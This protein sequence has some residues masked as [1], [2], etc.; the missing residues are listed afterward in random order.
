MMAESKFCDS[1][2]LTET[3]MFNL[4]SNDVEQIS[5]VK[6]FVEALLD[7]HK[8]AVDILTNLSDTL[9]SKYVF[10]FL[11]RY[12]DLLFTEH[13][14]TLI[15]LKSR[16]PVKSSSLLLLILSG[17]NGKFVEKK[18]YFSLNIIFCISFSF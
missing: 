9:S 7:Y 11:F 1:K 2:E 8:N 4:L 12:L 10:Y 15:S 16:Y 18:L 14:F 3:A 17:S 6:G 5:Q 13:N